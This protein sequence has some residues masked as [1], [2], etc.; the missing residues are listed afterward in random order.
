MTHF[1]PLNQI[2]SKVKQSNETW[3]LTDENSGGK[4]IRMETTK[5]KNLYNIILYYMYTFLQTI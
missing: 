4:Q 5:G 3:L 1:V 2:F